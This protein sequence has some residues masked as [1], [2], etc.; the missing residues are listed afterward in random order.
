MREDEITGCLIKVGKLYA[1]YLG[2]R[3]NLIVN[4]LK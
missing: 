4:K 1:V 2:K 3:R